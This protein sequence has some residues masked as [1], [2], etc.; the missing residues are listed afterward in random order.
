MTNR[1]T[2]I[3]L[4]TDRL[5]SKAWPGLSSWN[6]PKSPR[7]RE[8]LQRLKPHCAPEQ[9]STL[10]CSCHTVRNIWA[11]IPKPGTYRLCTCTILVYYSIKH[12]H[13]NIHFERIQRSQLTCSPSTT[14]IDCLALSIFKARA[15]WRAL[16]PGLGCAE[17]QIRGHTYSASYTMNARV[18]SSP[19]S[20]KTK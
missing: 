12:T 6:S 4:I 15:L 3:V 2:L 14:Q 11:C 13:K 1:N 18:L 5:R 10:F 7:G 9:Y 8:A 19:Y 20:W 17:D 16:C